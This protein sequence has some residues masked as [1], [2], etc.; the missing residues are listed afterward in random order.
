MKI[1]PS[2]NSKK[3]FSLRIKNVCARHLPNPLRMEIDEYLELL[4][5]KELRKLL[6]RPR[7]VHLI[8][9]LYFGQL[10]LYLEKNYATKIEATAKEQNLNLT[11]S[12]EGDYINEYDFD[13]YSLPFAYRM[14][15]L[16]RFN[17]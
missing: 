10:K 6:H 15:P 13:T 14:E 17:G 12:N 16:H 4:T 1:K 7:R 2:L 11:L 8:T 3:I 5:N 9:E